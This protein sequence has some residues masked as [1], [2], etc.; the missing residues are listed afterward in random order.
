MDFNDIIASLAFGIGFI[1]MYSDVKNS[2]ELDKKAKKRLILGVIASLLWLTYQSRKYGINTTTMYTT[3]GLLVQIY[4]L[5][6]ILLKDIK[7]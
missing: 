2:D 6:T 1:Q 5:N 4:L 7:D 3:V